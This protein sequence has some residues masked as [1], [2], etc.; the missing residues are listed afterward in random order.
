MLQPVE[1]RE[2]L[3]RIF[4][5]PL[6]LI[7]KHSTVCGLSSRAIRQVERFISRHPDV[8]A[9]IVD[10]ARNR[11]ISTE[12]EERLGVRHE[13]PQAIVVANGEVKWHGSHWGIRSKVLSKQI[14]AL[15]N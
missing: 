7:Y 3:E 11:A 2:E 14:A 15:N 1:N 9:Y 6:A 5:A 10:V 13:S 8:P 12:V 4:E